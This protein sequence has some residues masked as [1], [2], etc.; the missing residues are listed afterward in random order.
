MARE[1]VVFIDGSGLAF[2]AFFAIPLGL[3]TTD[4]RP[5]NATYGFARMFEKLFAGRHPVRGAVVFDAPGPTFRSERFPEYKAQRPKMPRELREQW[6]DIEALCSVHGFPVLRVPG[7]EADDVIGTLCR[8]AREAGDEV[9]IVSSDKDFA[10]LVRSEVRLLEP[11]KDVSYDPELVR[12]KWGVPPESFIDFLALTGDKVDNVPGVPGIGA[13]TAQ[14]LL[15]RFGD[16]EGVLAGTR[17]LKG[18]QKE[19]LETYAEDARLSRELVTIRQ[20]V[21][22]PAPYTELVVAPRDQD[23]VNRFYREL[24]FFSLLGAESAAD[25]I[26]ASGGRPVRSLAELDV[27]LESVG[28]RPLALVPIHG[29]A[30]P[31]TGAFLGVACALPE[32]ALEGLPAGHDLEQPRYV[33]FAGQD[34]LGDEARVRFGRYAS[35]PSRPKITHDARDLHCFAERF[36]FALAGVVGDTRLASF[37]IDP[38]RDI[39]HR[40]DQLARRWLGAPLVPEKEIRGSG[41]SEVELDTVPRDT[42]AGWAGHRAAAVADSW[43]PLAEALAE[44]PELERVLHEVSLPLARVLARMQVDGVRVSDAALQQ[45][46]TEFA[47]RRDAVAAEIHA[48]AGREF[49]IGS[50]KQ[51]GAVLFEELGLPIIKRTK[52]GY[53]T[54]ADVLT[55]LAPQHPVPALVLRW[56]AL[57]KLINTYTRV[58]REAIHPDTQRVHSTFQQTAGMSGRLITTDPD[59]QRT[60]IRTEDGKRIREAFIPREGRR[61]VSADWS[62]IELRLLAHVSGDPGLRSAFAEGLDVHRRTAAEIFDVPA[63]AVD[64][65][66]RNVGKT[67]NFATIYGQGATALGHSL[68]IKRGEAKKLIERYF[69]AYSGVR[70]WLDQTVAQAYEEGF[71]T[72]LI[73]RRRYIPELT[74]G[75]PSERGDGERI[76]TNTPIQGSAADLCELAMLQID[77]AITHEGLAA[78]M[79]LQIHDELIFEVPPDEVDALTTI[80]RRCMT[81]EMEERLALSVPLVVEVG[82]GDSWASAH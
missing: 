16:L 43:T 29:G 71:V 4:G 13:K 44:W 11:V 56:R 51:L 46:D 27:F 80:V 67:V 72:T 12:K 69:R 3:S 24:E 48:A 23:A 33:A 79:L 66:Q 6:D 5:T 49:N 15:A 82:V 42:L 52:T 8:E 61:M 74:T 73:G 41:K 30:N 10:Q 21:P 19:R 47:A 28:E 38:T 62:Q 39:P 68:G 18:K 64:P 34:G 76:A 9:I 14:S 20:D 65:Q 55:R 54:D 45:L 70:D 36:G 77:D 53:A 75:S 81:R 1:R 57:A 2:R 59:I 32:S 50:G 78:R 40:L 35:D 63:E 22:L 26:D 17:E 31:M 58:L 60:P 7:V 25:Q 37:L